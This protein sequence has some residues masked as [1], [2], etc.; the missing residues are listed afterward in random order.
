MTNSLLVHP[1][2]L[3]GANTATVVYTYQHRVSNLVYKKHL[4]LPS[5]APV[6]N[7]RST[8]KWTVTFWHL[9]TP[10]T[11]NMFQTCCLH[12]I[13]ICIDVEQC[14]RCANDDKRDESHSS[15]FFFFAK[16]VKEYGVSSDL[17]GSQSLKSSCVGNK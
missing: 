3:L 11:G 14:E 1:L 8:Y 2:L 9:S 6:R 15:E 12:R 17:E 4:N 16:T 10:T 13:S 7:I 5:H